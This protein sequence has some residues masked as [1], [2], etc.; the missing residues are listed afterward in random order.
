MC[1]CMCMLSICDWRVGS[2]IGMTYH[3][4]A[5]LEEALRER[6]TAVA[7]TCVVPCL[8]R[9]TLNMQ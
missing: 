8:Y 1:F 2:I 7:Y 9:L 3:Y 5:G 4:P 6:E